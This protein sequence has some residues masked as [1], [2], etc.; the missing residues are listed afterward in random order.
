MAASTELQKFP[1]YRDFQVLKCAEYSM[2]DLFSLSLTHIVTLWSVTPGA[3]SLKVR[4]P[5]VPK[6]LLSAESDGNMEKPGF[7]V[8]TAYC[9]LNKYLQSQLAV[10][11]SS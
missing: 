3:C 5:V 8:P 6:S 7:K 1:S 9:Q 10:Q 11:N 2:V 4:E